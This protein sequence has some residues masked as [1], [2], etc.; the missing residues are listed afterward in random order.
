MTAIHPARQAVIICLMG[1]TASGKTELAMA[2]ARHLPCDI[3]SVDSAQVYRGLTI[4]TAKPDSATLARFPHRLMNI[5]EPEEAYSVVRFRNDALSAIKASLA[6]GRIPL[7]VG[8]TMLYFKALLYGIDELP[9]ADPAVRAA[10]EQQADSEGWDSVHR[11]LAACDPDAAAR[12]HVGDTQRVQRALEVYLVSGRSMTSWQA[13]SPDVAAQ[14][15]PGASYAADLPCGVLPIA[16]APLERSVLHQRI[17]SRFHAMLAR[18][19]I[20]EV[21]VLRDSGAL[22]RGLPAMRAVGYRQVWSFLEGELTRDEMLERGIIATRQLAKRQLTWL[23]SWQ[24]LRWILTDA[25]GETV[26][27]PQALVGEA[28]LAAV[29]YYLRK[30]HD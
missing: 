9:A 18:G 27:E 1:P 28:P 11:R 14:K 2:I 29:N 30:F 23:R 25:S 7:L 13:R 8:G 10:I 22:L 26:L 21:R 6:A 19:L 16:L 12:L 15:R 17:A 4:G 20:E 24:D 5:L 3:I